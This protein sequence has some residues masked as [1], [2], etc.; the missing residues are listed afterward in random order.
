MTACRLCG[1]TALTRLFDFGPQPIAH[2]YLKSPEAAE[3]RHPFVIH[4]CQSC[5]LMQIIEPVPPAELYADD[6]SYV[7]SHQV[8][9]Q[10][11]DEIATLFGVC[12]PDRVLEIA[13][14]DGAFLEVLAERGITGCVGVESNAPVAEI[15]RAKGLTV[16]PVFFD[17]S[18]VGDLTAAH[19]R[20]DVVIAR[21]IMEHI[22]D[23]DGYLSG[24]RA[25]TTDDATLLIELPD[26]EAGLDAGDASFLWEEHVNYFTDELL[27][28]TLAA[29]G[30]RTLARRKYNRGGGCLAVFA[31]K[32]DLPSAAEKAAVLSATPHRKIAAM[33][34]AVE[35]QGAALRAA[36]DDAKR[37]GEVT[38]IYGGG[39]RAVILINVH[40]LADKVDRII[41]DRADLNGLLLP[42]SRLRID[43][44]DVLPGIDAPVFFLMAVSNENEWK[45]KRKVR[46]L[47]PDRARF[48]SMLGPR[49][50]LGELAAPRA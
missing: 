14:N 11:D 18:T 37:R 30:F 41:D 39:F 47:I 34:A 22:G 15:A 36:L 42:G 48:A 1:S 26:I 13:C 23:L 32:T 50:F 43:S 40:G 3:F 7:T 33:P 24:I 17:M 2:R 28:R 45:V 16:E 6:A 38:A 31:R 44:S 25:A 46:A 35:R 8:Q 20:F 27:E 49:D 10:L 21:Q 4:A 12:D 19:G 9:H 29:Y 5:G